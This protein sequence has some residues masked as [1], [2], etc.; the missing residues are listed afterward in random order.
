MQGLAAGQGELDLGLEAGARGGPL[1]ITSSRLG[2]L[3]D[4]VSH[5]Y[6]VLGFTAAA[7]GD[8]VFFQLVAARIIEPFN[9]LHTTG[10]RCVCMVGYGQSRRRGWRLYA[11]A[12][13]HAAGE[14][15]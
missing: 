12:R 2:G 3:L 1:P 6:D 13:E 10:R 5:A 14:R 4:A 15:G 8:E 7:D 11:A 9:S